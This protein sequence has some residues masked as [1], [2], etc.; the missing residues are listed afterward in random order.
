V[1]FRKTCTQAIDTKQ[2]SKSPIPS[3]PHSRSGPPAKG[4]RATRDALR[5]LDKRLLRCIVRPVIGRSVGVKYLAH[6]QKPH[7]AL[8]FIS[9]ATE[10]PATCF[11][12]LLSP[13]SLSL[14]HKL[15][16]GT[17]RVDFKA[18]SNQPYT[19]SRSTL[20]HHPYLRCTCCA[21]GHTTSSLYSPSLHKA[22]SERPAKSSIRPRATSFAYLLSALLLLRNSYQLLLNKSSVIPTNSTIFEQLELVT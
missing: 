21:S 9:S 3:F 13:L 20:A 6:S 4:T 15:L 10:S 7:S 14:A 18:C 11:P 19:A 16:A 22:V 17:L 8:T 5:K 12:Y 1:L 2:N